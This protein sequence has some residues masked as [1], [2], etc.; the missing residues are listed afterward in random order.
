[1]CKSSII[2]IRRNV[3]SFYLPEHADISGLDASYFKK[4]KKPAPPPVVAQLGPIVPQLG[5]IVPQLGLIVAQLGPM[6]RSTRTAKQLAIRQV[7]D[8]YAQAKK[9]CGAKGGVWHVDTN[10]CM[11]REC[12]D[13]EV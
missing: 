13:V 9:D 8:P 4:K 1:M 11:K 12:K 6:I 5:P 7:I 2:I 3:M 10:K